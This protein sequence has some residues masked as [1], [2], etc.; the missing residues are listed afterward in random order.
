[1]PNTTGLTPIKTYT[2]VKAVATTR[3]RK[4]GRGS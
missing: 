4:V 1:L 3:S 2:P